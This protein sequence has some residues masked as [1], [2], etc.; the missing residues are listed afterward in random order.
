[1]TPMHP[2]DPDER[3]AATADDVGKDVVT[4]YG[5]HVGT[6]AAVDEHDRRVS[7][8]VAEGAAELLA[9]TVA[10]DDRD[11]GDAAADVG[12]TVELRAED[13]GVITADRV[14]LRN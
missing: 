14:W 8:D 1:M 6:V 3:R 5:E 9:S 11:G 12:S 4:S 10:A 13:V 2:D 7:V